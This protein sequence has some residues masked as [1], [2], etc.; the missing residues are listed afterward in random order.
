[1]ILGDMKA[2]AQTHA[3]VELANALASEHTVF[4]CNAGPRLVDDDVRNRLSPRL[5][6]AE[7]TVGPTPWSLGDERISEERRI[8]QHRRARVLR[9][10][11]RLL[12][13]DLVHSLSPAADRLAHAIYSETPVAW[14]VHAESVIRAPSPVSEPPD[15]RVLDSSIIREARGF[16][17]ASNAELALLEE[18][19]P[20]G[21]I[22]KL[23][24]LLE[25]GKPASETAV[26][27]TEAYLEACNLLAFPPAVDSSE[28]S[29]ADTSTASRK[30]A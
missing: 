15:L 17:Y 8:G 26:S 27:C 11:I 30:L 4:L 18:Q 29:R 25:P 14:V 2:K 22:E 10:L 12:H 3:A 5:I 13:V 1:L 7:G 23:R 20:T 6:L 21:L 24:W 28:A 16:F 9:E 19:A